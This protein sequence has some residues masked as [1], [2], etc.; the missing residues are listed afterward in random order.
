MSLTVIMASEKLDPALVEE[1]I[2]FNEEIHFVEFDSNASAAIRR[3]VFWLR[4]AGLPHYPESVYDLLRYWKYINREFTLFF[5]SVIR[6]YDKPSL[7][8]LSDAVKDYLLKRCDDTVV[9]DLL[10]EVVCYNI[11]QSPFELE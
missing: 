1:L 5:N 11:L 8:L 9:R 7:W 3:L 4:T 2:N 10:Q 6:Y